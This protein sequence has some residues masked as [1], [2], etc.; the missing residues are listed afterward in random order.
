[1]SEIL[2]IAIQLAVV[3]TALRPYV[4]VPSAT[5]T[6]RVYLS[7]TPSPVATGSSRSAAQNVTPVTSAVGADWLTAMTEA[8]MR[9]LPLGSSVMVCVTPKSP[10]VAPLALLVHCS[11]NWKST[12]APSA[13][14]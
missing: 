6:S 1:M 13:A 8:L 3:P 14:L 11:M 5:S 9:Y 7:G 2:S 10:R 4:S 12:R